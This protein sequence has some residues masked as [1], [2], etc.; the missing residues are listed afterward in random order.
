LLAREAGLEP[1]ENQA[2][3]LPALRRRI[4]RAKSTFGMTDRGRQFAS[5]GLLD[6][7][8]STL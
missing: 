3:K 2:G 6:R 8:S 5:G 4:P 1:Q 7:R